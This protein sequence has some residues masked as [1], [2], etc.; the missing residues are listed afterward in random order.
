MIRVKEINV[1]NCT[2]DFFDEVIN[3]KN[4]DLNHIK[5]DKK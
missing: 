3:I 4:L 2:Y 1:I 5:I